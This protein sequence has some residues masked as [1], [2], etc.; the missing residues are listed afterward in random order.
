MNYSVPEKQIIFQVFWSALLCIETGGKKLI[1]H[2]VHH[3]IYVLLEAWN[4]LM[5]WCLAFN[6][7]K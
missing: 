3:N 5:S 7:T 1:V 4:I 2:L 6:S